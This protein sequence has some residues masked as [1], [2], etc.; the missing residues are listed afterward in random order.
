MFTKTELVAATVA[1][2]CVVVAFLLLGNRGELAISNDDQ[3]ATVAAGLQSENRTIITPTINTEPP[4]KIEDVKTGTGAEVT[5]GDTVSV[6]YSGRF[7]NGQ[8]FDNSK[9]RGAPLDFTVGAGQVIPGWEQGLLGMQ[10]GGERTLVIP[11]E[12]AYGEQGIGPIPGGATLY[13]TV[14][15]LEIK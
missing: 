4:M 1:T 11:P 12:L 3:L 13:F 7:E 14:E 10:V 15:L 5:E 8:E 9:K 6:H 2:A